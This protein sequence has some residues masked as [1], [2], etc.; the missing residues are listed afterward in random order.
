MPA[1]TLAARGESACDH[2]SPL[3]RVKIEEMV[4]PG[5]AWYAVYTRA[6]HEK[7]VA[8]ELC[9][10]QI[11]CFI[12]LQERLSRWKDRRKLVQFPLFPGYLFVR[13]EMQSRRLDILRVP[14]IVRIIG[15]NGVP[16]PIPPAQIEAVKNL[17]FN[18]IPMD[19]HPFI[20]EGDRVRI[21]RGPLRGVEGLLLEKKNRYTFI[22][23]IDLIQ[24][25]VGCE[26]EAADVEKV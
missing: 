25:S 5:L 21:I 26:I 16:E 19:P 22:L 12:P 14:S 2:S 9:L 18:E 15:F 13:T 1:F 6:R 23:S 10:R 7:V 8:E 3:R 4:E 11:E 24:Q 17:V 20:R